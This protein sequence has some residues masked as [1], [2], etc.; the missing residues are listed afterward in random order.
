M[1]YDMNRIKNRFSVS[2]IVLVLFIASCP[3]YSFGQPANNQ[4]KVDKS[5]ILSMFQHQSFKSLDSKL[6]E[7]QSAYDKDY[8]EEDNVYDAFEVFSRVDTVF[9]SM[10][11]RW[12]KEFSEFYAPYVARAKYYCACARQARGRKWIIDKDQKEYKEM[13]RYFSLALLDINTALKK[14]A[15]LDVC[16]AMLVEIGSATSDKEMKSSALGDGLKNHPYAYRIR[17]K[18]LQALAPRLG[19]SYDEMSTFID[20]CSRYAA[21]NSKLKE[22]FAC[23]PADKGNVFSYLGKYGEAVKMYTEALNYSNYHSY[24]A[25]RGDAY[26]Q[27]HDYLHALNDYNHALELSPND[28]EYLSRKDKAI[29]GQNSISERRNAN[30]YAPRFESNNKGTQDQSLISER[31]NA[32]AHLSKGNSLSNEGRY[33]D[34]VAEYSEA[35]RI[36]PYEY[37]PYINRA[38]CYSQLHN[39]DAELQD[40]LRVIELKPDYTNAYLRITTIYANHG[41]YDNAL[42]TINK[43][44]SLNPNNGEALFTR[45]RIYER[46][47]NNIEAM[48]DM[49][50]ACDLGYQ[51]AC[52]FYRMK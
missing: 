27:L 36:V 37:I 26:I 51:R 18:Y 46:L 20:S 1:K 13:E 17:L 33:E 43:M 42:N 24:Y 44:L 2:F 48:Q 30:Q 38:I 32:N 15:Q 7:Y 52:G 4:R 34:A 41:M 49:Q 16:Y 23:I 22:L 39:E 35:I 31:I 6:E 45:G 29:A 28:P 21:F 8:Q 3:M 19:G 50:Q 14:N 11:G 5:I 10:L 12:I 40:F 9:E 25:D 47:G